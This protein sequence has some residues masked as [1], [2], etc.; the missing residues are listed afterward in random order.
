[1]LYILSF[2]FL[3]KILVMMYAQM[4]D[5]IIKIIVIFRCF[6]TLYSYSP[7]SLFMGWTNATRGVARTNRTGWTDCLQSVCPNT[8]SAVN[9]SN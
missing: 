9:Y 1:M 3:L 4:K 5:F 2:E 8:R 7:C 6:L